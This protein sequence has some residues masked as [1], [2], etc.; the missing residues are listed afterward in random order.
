VDASFYALN[1]PR[2]RATGAVV[3]RLGRGWEVRI[4]NE[5]RRQSDSLLRR[6]SNRDAFLTAAVVAFSPSGWKG[7]TLSLQAENLWN[8]DF[9]EVPAV[10]A[11]RRQVVFGVTYRR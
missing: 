1:F 10:P 2:F 4:D 7:V 11:G 9:E 6:A 3:V 8:D 5:V